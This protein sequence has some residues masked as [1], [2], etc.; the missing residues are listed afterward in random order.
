VR[1]SKEGVADALREMREV[2]ERER[3]VEAVVHVQSQHVGMLLGKGGATINAVQKESGALLDMQ[4]KADEG[5]SVQA[6]TIRGN[7]AQVKRAQA[8]LEAVLM[9]DA[10]SNAVLVVEAAMMP[11]LIGKGGEEINRIRSL[12]GAAIDA[13][14]DE[15]KP[16]F[17]LRG[18]KEAVEAARAA[19]L[20]S[21][22]SNTRVGVHVPLPWH[23]MDIIVGRNGE[24]LRKLETDYQV[25]ME[26]PGQS[27]ESEQVGSGSFLA[28]TT[29]LLLRGR[30]K[31]VDTAAVKLEQ[32]SSAYAT[33]EVQLD[34][35]D[36]RLLA[37]LCLAEEVLLEGLEREHDVTI[38]FAPVEGVLRFRGE[39]RLAASRSVRELLRCERPTELLVPC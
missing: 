30:K 34:D 10:E 5:S 37:E 16:Q 3:K 9:Y 33:E 8:A 15:K 17:K 24:S 18:S 14:R 19:L 21:I 23:C 39:S 28:I 4:K 38:R 20:E 7:A 1:G 36:A 25:Q 22:E 27:L 6:V 31:H 12:T 13:E 26:L 29:S 2:I 32:L 35:D 11:L